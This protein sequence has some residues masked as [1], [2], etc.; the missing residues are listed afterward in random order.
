MIFRFLKKSHKI[1]VFWWDKK[2]LKIAG[3]LEKQKT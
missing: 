1:S 3:F 2:I